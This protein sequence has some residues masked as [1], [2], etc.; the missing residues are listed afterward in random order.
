MQAGRLWKPAG[1]ETVG[2][3]Y[4][5][6][7]GSRLCWRLWEPAMPE[8]VGAGYAGDPAAASQL[9]AST[10]SPLKRLPQ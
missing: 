10:H 4:A 9:A 3:G 6:D 8:T 2:A 7:C 5:G 1:L